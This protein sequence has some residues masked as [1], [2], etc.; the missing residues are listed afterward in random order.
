MRVPGRFRWVR[1]CH[2][3][4]E[5]AE[6]AAVNAR[7][8]EHERAVRGAANPIATSEPHCMRGPPVAS[9]RSATPG[10]RETPHLWEGT[11]SVRPRAER[12]K[13]PALAERAAE[14][15]STIRGKRAERAERTADPARA[16]LRERPVM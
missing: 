3:A 1:A 11:A 14:W 13:R 8:V 6:R 7:T 16:R 4:S 5:K 15:E 12:G 10:G 2:G 9:A